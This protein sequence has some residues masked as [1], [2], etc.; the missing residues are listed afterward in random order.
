M[1]KLFVRRHVGRHQRLARG[2]TGVLNANVPSKR[3]V[4]AISGVPD[5]VTRWSIANNTGPA[6]TIGIAA[7]P[8]SSVLNRG[9][10]SSLIAVTD[11]VSVRDRRG[12]RRGGNRYRYRGQDDSLQG[13]FHLTTIFDVGGAAKFGV[14]MR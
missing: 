14:G 9:I 12:S 8:S 3:S 13:R 10:S 1:S 2:A 4:A 11:V 5:G 6:L 7:I